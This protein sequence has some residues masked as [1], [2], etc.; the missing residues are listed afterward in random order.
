MLKNARVTLESL[1][2]G[3]GTGLRF[4]AAAEGVPAITLDSGAGAAGP[5]PMDAVL[6]ALGGCMAMDVISILRKKRLEVT[7][8]D[9]DL[10]ADRAEQHP[11]VFQAVDMVHRVRGRNVSAAA[12][13]EA[14]HLSETKYCSVS[15]M[16]QK[17]V[18]IRTRVEVV[19]EAP[20]A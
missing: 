9:V 8:Y 5:S 1:S 3:D 15:A 12:V 11:K 18:T 10:V 19:E 2:A 14:V 16:L 4:R 13:E 17:S 7:A 6:V 20:A